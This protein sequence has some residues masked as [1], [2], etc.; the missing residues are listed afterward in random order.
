MSLKKYFFKNKITYKIYLF[1]NLYI[2][3]K[4][5]INRSQYSQWG[6]D[7]FIVDYFK[8]KNN[9]TYFDVGCFHPI[10][11]SNTCLLYKKGW[12][13]VNLDINPTSI[14]LFDIIRPDDFNLCTTIDENK[15]EFKIY[16]D[17]PL[18]PVNTLDKKYYENSK[19]IFFKNSSIGSVKS[20]SIDEIL[21][22]SKINKVDFLNID[23]EGMDFKILLQLIPNKLQPQLISIETYNVDGSKSDECDKIDEFLKNCNYKCYKRIGPSSLYTL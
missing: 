10:M 5:F 22:L 7:L 19:K 11:Y 4:C 23:A 3:H 12:R 20:K 2:R 17:H 13:G 1:Y 6:E 14:H 18:S 9:G 15:N 21:K 8:N 16:F